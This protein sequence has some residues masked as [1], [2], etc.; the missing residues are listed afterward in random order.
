M[1]IIFSESE[2]F[3]ESYTFNYAVYAE[4]EGDDLSQIYNSGFLP[5]TDN[6]SLEGNR[7]YL[8][9]SLRVKL[10]D[11]SLNSENRRILRKIEGQN[12][13]C[14]IMAAKKLVDD[15]SFFDFCQRYAEER[16]HG[17]SLS[18][19][20]LRYILNWHDDTKLWEYRLD[21]QIMGYVLGIEGTDFLH[22]WYSFYNLKLSG[23]LPLGKIL[24]T[25]FIEEAA[26]AKVKYVY[27][28]TCYHKRSLYKARDYNSV[29]FYDGNLWNDK[30]YE[31]KQRCK[32]DDREEKQRLDW[33]KYSD[34][35]AI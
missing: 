20:R 9:R 13:N 4:S 5:Y 31:L 29:E 24:M 19:K 34:S 8:C 16:F 33:L 17:R 12:M 28:G 6:S 10:N 30:L 2:P 23:Q 14:R 1:K 26:R 32:W 27:L 3:Y 18:E 25:K 11:F 35:E 7:F 15:T 21:D 22:Y